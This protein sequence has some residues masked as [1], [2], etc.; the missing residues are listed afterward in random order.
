[1]KNIYWSNFWA[2]VLVTVAYVVLTYFIEDASYV[3]PMTTLVA[4]LAFAA[5]LLRLAYLNAVAFL[6]AASAAALA[7]PMVY[8]GI[9]TLAVALALALL[10]TKTKQN[11]I[12]VCLVSFVQGCADLGIFWV[13]R[14]FMP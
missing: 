4:V 2:M 3:A 8:Y 7:A 5:A 10:K 14:H 6:V 12:K 1:M 9:V 11:K 13:I